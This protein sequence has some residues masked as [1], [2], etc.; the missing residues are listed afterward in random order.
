MSN[1]HPFPSTKDHAYYA[2]LGYEPLPII[3]PDVKI[4]PR[5]TLYKRVGTEQDGRGK[6]PGRLNSEGTWGSYDWAAYTPDEQ[7]FPRWARM[8]AGVGIKTGGGLLAIDADTT[9]E[10]LARKIKEIVDKHIGKTPVRV[11]RFPKALYVV[12][13]SE[14]TPYKRV[15]FGPVAKD[16]KARI[17]RVE[18]LTSGKQFVAEG[19]H[20]KTGKPYR[21][22]RDLLSF[23]DLPIVSPET[24]DT[25]LDEIRQAMPDSGPVKVEGAGSV[26]VDQTALKGDPELVRKAVALLPNTNEHFSQREDYRDVGYAIKASMP[27][28][29]EGAFEIFLDWCLRWENGEN[30]P[31]IV[32]ADWSRM[33][34]PFRRGAKWLFELSENL[35]GGKFQ[36]AEMWLEDYGDEPEP[37]DDPDDVF[38]LE[39][40]DDL[41]NKPEPEW[42]IDRYLPKEGVGF[43][44]APPASYKTFLALDMALHVASGGAQWNGDDIAAGETRRVLYLAAEGSYSFGFRVKAWMKQNPLAGS[45]TKSFFVLPHSVNFTKPDQVRKFIR[46]AAKK[47]RFDLTI[48]DTVSRVIPG[49]DENTQKDMSMFISA[50]EATQKEVGGVVVGIHHA[51]KSGEGMRGSSV[52]QGAGDFVFRLSRKPGSSVGETYCEK[53]KDGPDDWRDHYSYDLV[54]VGESAKG[55]P[56]TSLVPSRLEM[57]G[58][59]SEDVT[60]ELT[61]RVLS[62]MR[63]AHK[64][65][66][67]WAKAKQAGERQAIRRMV[68]DFDLSAMVAENLLHVWEQTG[69]IAYGLASSHSKKKGY[70]VKAEPGQDVGLG[71]VFD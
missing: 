40:V 36:A 70:S 10:D 22:V 52:L 54:H 6:T 15:E 13:T 21:W 39:T 9:D 57:G 24:I 28:D 32:A 42:L 2:A 67:P 60:P 3:P 26:D 29:P 8:G 19:V 58:K 59:G 14:P 5:S 17:W 35:S 4:S 7:D 41:F 43:I 61:E 25:V 48:V 53:M 68:A 69:V 30:D 47:G 12:R 50:C 16:G 65:G 71:G 46:T 38:H 64:K 20:P 62:A 23:D 51:N 45:L 56:L 31:D 18:M 33:K 11:G 27:D 44:Y 63:E 55:K 37:E 66:E 49:A 34:P 1:V